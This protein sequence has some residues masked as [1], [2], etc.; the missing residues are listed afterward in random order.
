[1]IKSWRFHTFNHKSSNVFNVSGDQNQMSGSK[2][3]SQHQFCQNHFHVPVNECCDWIIWNWTDIG[4]N[5]MMKP[6]HQRAAANRTRQNPIGLY[7][8]ETG[9]LKSSPSWLAHSVNKKLRSESAAKDF[10][11]SRI[12]P[13]DPQCVPVRSGPVRP[14]VVLYTVAGSL[15]HSVVEFVFRS[16]MFTSAVFLL[17]C[18]VFEF[19][20]TSLMFDALMKLLIPDTSTP[21]PARIQ[22][23]SI[24]ISRQNNPDLWF[25]LTFCISIAELLINRVFPSGSAQ[26]PVLVSNSELFYWC[27]FYFEGFI[28]LPAGSVWSQNQSDRRSGASVF[29][30]V[31]YFCPTFSLDPRLILAPDPTEPDCLHCII[32][33]CMCFLMLNDAEWPD[34]RLSVHW[35]TQCAAEQSAGQ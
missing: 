20:W 30:A 3:H 19:F 9:R 15:S 26:S 8:S 21:D 27:I 23:D 10:S 32:S 22:C 16:N 28:R 31:C 33:A 34:D 18:T 29:S 4:S 2:S 24:R 25:V 12:R 7:R 35:E 5:L 13:A 11:F 17:H 14:P 6:A 1:M